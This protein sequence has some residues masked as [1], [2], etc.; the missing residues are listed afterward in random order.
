M[1][2]EPMTLVPAVIFYEFGYKVKLKIRVISFSFVYFN[3]SIPLDRGLTCF[4]R[5]V[6]WNSEYGSTR[7][8]TV[9]TSMLAVNNVLTVYTTMYISHCKT[10]PLLWVTL[11]CI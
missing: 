3:A 5:A 9:M 6:Y 7:A 10:I 1:C 8:E 2:D 4:T 11:R